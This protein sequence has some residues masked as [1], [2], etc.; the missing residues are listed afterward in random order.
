MSTEVANL[1]DPLRQLLERVVVEAQMRA[2]DPTR[3]HPVSELDPSSTV[4]AVSARL[5]GG[6][7]VQ[8]YAEELPRGISFCPAG[9]E[10]DDARAAALSQAGAEAIDYRLKVATAMVDL[11]V[12][13][14]SEA[15][16]TNPR[17]E[18]E[19][20]IGSLLLLASSLGEDPLEISLGAVDN[21]GAARWVEQD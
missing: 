9:S 18:I 4:E 3:F 2:A 5:R 17:Y 7:V 6:D 11:H 20:A 21:Y 1:P 12:R 10:E 13:F 19:E 8:A 16:G 14:G 15:A